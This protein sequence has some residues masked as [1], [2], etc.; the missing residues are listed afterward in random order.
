MKESE[1]AIKEGNEL[2]PEGGSSSAASYSYL[3]IVILI[4][5]VT[6]R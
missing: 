6:S 2:P 3:I 4:W 5:F 1:N